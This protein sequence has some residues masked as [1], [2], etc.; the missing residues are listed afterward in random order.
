MLGTIMPVAPAQGAGRADHPSTRK[1]L[2]RRSHPLLR[3]APPPRTVLGRGRVRREG[4]GR[5]TDMQHVVHGKG[6][7]CGAL[8]GPAA[9]PPCDARGRRRRG[10]KALHNKAPDTAQSGTKNA[11]WA[12]GFA[13]ETALD[14]RHKCCDQR[15][16]SVAP[17]SRQRQIIQ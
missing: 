2:S 8:P 16:N 12:A 11:P 7:G 4:E 6:N 10:T 14:Q 3:Q 1:T 17:G 5:H 15:W 13:A 9:A